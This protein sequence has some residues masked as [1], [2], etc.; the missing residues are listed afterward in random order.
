LH[1]PIQFFCYPTGEPFHHDSLAEQKLVLND[2]FQDGYLGATLDPSVFNSALQN[3]QIPYQMPRI[4]VSG[5]ET[6]SEFTGILAVT[7][8][9]DRLRLLQLGKTA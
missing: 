6:L 1:E 5:G 2:L 3:S 4:R 8:A 9:Q 7:L